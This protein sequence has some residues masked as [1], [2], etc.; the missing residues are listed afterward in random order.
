MTAARIRSPHYCQ[1]C[2]AEQP[3]SLVLAAYRADG[4][5]WCRAHVPAGWTNYGTPPEGTQAR[6]EAA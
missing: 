1:V 4:Q 6:E 2:M 3:G 5:A